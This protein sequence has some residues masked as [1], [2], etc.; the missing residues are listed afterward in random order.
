MKK[1]CSHVID[2]AF[3]ELRLHR[4]NAAYMPEN[5]RSEHLLKSL[6]FSK[7]GFAKS[8]LF[9]NGAWE[10]HIIASLINNKDI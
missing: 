7:E 2:F 10:D 6:G 1:L 4:I 3:D 8:Y 5:I 9:I